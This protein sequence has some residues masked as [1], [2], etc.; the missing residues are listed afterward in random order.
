MKSQELQGYP[1]LLPDLSYSLDWSVHLLV[2][3]LHSL[4][5]DISIKLLH[6]CQRISKYIK[7]YPIKLHITLHW[8]SDVGK[9]LRGSEEKRAEERTFR[10]QQRP[11]PPIRPSHLNPTR[12]NPSPYVNFYQ[13]ADHAMPTKHTNHACDKFFQQYDRPELFHIQYIQNSAH[14]SFYRE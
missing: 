14:C 10:P 9:L 5:D 6:I 12:H 11:S 7:V 1:G 4:L 3:K 13:C 2:W 8:G